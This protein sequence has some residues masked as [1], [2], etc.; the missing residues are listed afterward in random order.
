MSMVISFSIRLGAKS[1]NTEQILQIYAATPF[2]ILWRCIRIQIRACVRY[3]VDAVKCAA[4]VTCVF[5]NLWL[6][7][8][9]FWREKLRYVSARF[10]CRHC[11]VFKLQDYQNSCV[12]W[13]IVAYDIRLDFAA[14]ETTVFQRA[15]GTS[16]WQRNVA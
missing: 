13:T 9:Q 2:P 12:S 4:F 14:A 11:K 1:A 6:V 15:G 16:S 7:E 5:H 3:T 10:P 8:N